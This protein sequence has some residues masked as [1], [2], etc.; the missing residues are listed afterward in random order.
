MYEELTGVIR[1][2]LEI[3]DYDDIS[4]DEEIMEFYPE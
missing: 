4:D 1:D 3:S 2:N